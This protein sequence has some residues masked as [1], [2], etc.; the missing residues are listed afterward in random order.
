MATT[1]TAMAATRRRNV[2]G[3]V[4]GINAF[5]QPDVEAAK[6]KTRELTAAFEKSGSLPAEQPV[7]S[8]D[9]ADQPTVTVGAGAPGGNGEVTDATPGTVSA[10][11]AGM[12]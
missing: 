2:A 10:K 5:N 9:E 8:T 4:L 6:V 3:S 1:I 11:K 12:S 7:I